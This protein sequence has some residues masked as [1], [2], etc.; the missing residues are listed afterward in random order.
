MN[1]EENIKRCVEIF[2]LCEANYIIAN[3]PNGMTRPQ[4]KTYEDMVAYQD[5]S[6]KLRQEAQT[7]RDLL[8]ISPDYDPRRCRLSRD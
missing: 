4:F 3:L 7:A 6:N 2:I 8:P 5:A 1:E